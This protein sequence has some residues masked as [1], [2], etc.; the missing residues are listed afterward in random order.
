MLPHFELLGTLVFSYPLMM[1]I[2][3][4]VALQ[5]AKRLNLR[6]Q[7]PLKRLNI[8]AAG[9]FVFSWIGAKLFYVFTT[10]IEGG[11]RFLANPNFWLGGGFV[12]Y[13][14]LIFG[15]VFLFLFSLVARQPLNRFN[16]LIPAAALGHG[17]GRVGCFLAGCCYGKEYDGLGAVWLHGADR[18]PTQLLEAS[19]LFMFGGWAATRKAQG[20]RFLAFEYLLFYALARFLL[21]YLRGDQIRGVWEFGLTSSQV[22]SL[23]IA[24]CGAS[25]LWLLRKPRKKDSASA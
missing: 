1:G 7:T 25:A 12:F 20:R 24:L 8:L 10:D 13:G 3:W 2:A 21:E 23:I 17:V 4:G 6:S 5:V 19:V 15:L 14:G 9:V 18:Y 22:I 16:L 11:S